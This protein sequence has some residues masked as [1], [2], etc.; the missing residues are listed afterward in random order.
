LQLVLN[1]R[2]QIRAA[3]VV[4]A[5]RRNNRAVFECAHGCEA[6]KRGARPRE[7]TVPSAAWV[8]L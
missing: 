4:G 1:A 7:G 2:E 5:A 8:W 6:L 3:M